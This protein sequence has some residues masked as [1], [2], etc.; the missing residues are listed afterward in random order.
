MKHVY[1]YQEIATLFEQGRVIKF[2][3]PLKVLVT[4]AKKQD[5]PSIHVTV[6]LLVGEYAIGDFTIEYDS[7]EA[8]LDAFDIAD[9]TE[10][11]ELLGNPGGVKYEQQS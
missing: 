10:I 4:A 1:S 2:I 7:I 11:F 5:S 9:H 8:L 3:H 6:V